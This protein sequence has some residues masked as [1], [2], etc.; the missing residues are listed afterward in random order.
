MMKY[1]SESCHDLDKMTSLLDSLRYTEHGHV[2]LAG[3]GGSADEHVLARPV[4]CIAHHRLNPVK[5]IRKEVKKYQH[6]SQIRQNSVKN[7]SMK[8]VK[9]LHSREGSSTNLVECFDRHQFA[10]DVDDRRVLSGG[11]AHFLEGS[12]VLGFSN[13]Y[14]PKFLTLD[15]ILL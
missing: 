9:A 8:P 15:R 14:L 7:C 6:L 10:P 2:G 1:F 11:D 13:C 3:A 4:R 12:G 5:E